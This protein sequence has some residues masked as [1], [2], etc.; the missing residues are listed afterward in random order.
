MT[1]ESYYGRHSSGHEADRT[2]GCGMPGVTQLATRTYVVVPGIEETDGLAKAAHDTDA[3]LNTTVT[4]GGFTRCRLHHHLQACHLDVWLP[5]A[6]I[7]STNTAWLCPYT[8]WLCPYAAWPTTTSPNRM[9]P[10]CHPPLPTG[11]C[12]LSGL[13]HLRAHTQEEKLARL[14]SEGLS[15]RR[16]RLPANVSEG[17]LRPSFLTGNWRRRHRESCQARWSRSTFT[18]STSDFAAANS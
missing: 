18:E 11:P 4:A 8:A 15:F 6:T 13:L 17:G 3:P 7:A 5:D 10:V 2:P 14:S 12:T 9:P 1:G 16:E